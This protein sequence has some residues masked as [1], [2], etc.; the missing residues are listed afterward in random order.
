LTNGGVVRVPS[1]DGVVYDF[2]TPQGLHL[3]TIDA[4]TG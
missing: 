3:R 1:A 4:L 2:S